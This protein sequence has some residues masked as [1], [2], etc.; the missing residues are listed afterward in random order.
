MTIKIERD[1]FLRV[2]TRKGPLI[3]KLQQPQQDE[4]YVVVSLPTAT[5][6]GDDFFYDDLIPVSTD[7]EEQDDD[8]LLSN[9]S[10][11]TVSDDDE[12]STASSS[13]RV[14]FADDLVTDVYTRD[15]TLPEEVS[16]L[17]YTALETQTVGV[18]FRA[19]TR[20]TK[21]TTFYV[22]SVLENSTHLSTCLLPFFFLLNLCSSVN[23]IG[24]NAR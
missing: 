4:E 13:R 23:N 9:D 10:A 17:Y 18:A 20:R 6:K 15:K 12:A 14:S 1:A 21:S 19:R 16:R 11:S 3:E 24:S 22:C 5:N 8:S 7:D 2:I